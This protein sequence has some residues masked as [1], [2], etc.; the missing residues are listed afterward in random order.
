MS[1][2]VQP[3]GI[4]EAGSKPCEEEEQLAALFEQVPRL[5][6]ADEDLARR[7]ALLGVRF[8]VGIGSIPFDVTI[9]RGHV[10]SVERGPRMMGSWRFAVWGTAE[11]WRRLWKPVPEPGWHDLLALTK[12]GAVRIE[13]DLHP[14]MTNLQYVKD[15]LA[16]PRRLV[17]EAR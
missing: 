2:R 12:R 9:A 7:G 17:K 3:N 10:V 16:L 4:A 14:L 5:A 11:A 15:L 13:G 8:Q 1:T 6:E